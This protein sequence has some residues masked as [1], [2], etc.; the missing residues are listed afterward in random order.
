ME[1][2]NRF[3]TWYSDRGRALVRRV[4]AAIGA[5][6]WLSPNLVTLSGTALNGVAAVLVVQESYL[7]ASLVFVAGSAL[8]AVDGAIAKLQ[9]RVTAWGG[10]LDS[11]MDRVSEGLVLTGLGLLFAAQGNTLALAACFV[12]LASSYLVSYTR[13]RAEAAGAGA[14][15]GLASRVERVLLIGLGMFVATWW[16][17]ALAWAIYVVALSAS[18]TVLQ[19]VLHVRRQ[20]LAASP[21]TP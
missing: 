4:L 20:L 6:R 16:E 19:R 5:D 11:T 17:P 3:R 21:D 9:D 18:L 14:A 8:D 10:F 15:V 1:D 13:A 2:E 12:A 7:A